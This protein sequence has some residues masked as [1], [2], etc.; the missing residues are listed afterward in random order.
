MLYSDTREITT[1]KDAVKARFG[2]SQP[3]AK[4]PFCSP[5]PKNSILVGDL[6]DSREINLGFSPYRKLI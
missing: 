6:K 4:P 5:S 3:H 1:L 2:M